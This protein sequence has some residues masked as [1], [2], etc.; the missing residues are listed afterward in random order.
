MSPTEK[1]AVEPVMLAGKLCGPGQP[2]LL[3]AELSG[4]HGGDIE[5]ALALVDAAVAAGADLVKIQT[6]RPDTITVDHDG[7]EFRIESGLWQGRTLYE[8]YAEAHTPWEWHEALFARAR[9]HGVPMFS[10]PFDPTAVDLLESL[11]CPAYKI[12]SFE[13]VDHG[14]IERVAATGKP[15]VLSTGIAS[16][17][18][19]DEAVS[20]LK[21]YP[22]TPFILLHCT[23]GYPTPI[24]EAD[25]ATI[26]MLMERYR[27]PV[28][29]S[30]HTLGI[31]VPIAAVALG[32]CLVEKHFTLDR[33][34]G[35]VDAAFSLD[36][37]EFS[38]MA[39]A[40]REA[41]L[42]IGQPR[43]EMAPV[44]HSQK[45]FRRSLYA[46]AD[47]PAGSVITDAQVRSVRPG[48]GL[49][50]REL[51][52]VLGCRAR[53]AIKKGTPIAWELL[54]EVGGAGE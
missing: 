42:A 6:Y 25:L 37:D 49:H 16:L 50:P 3:I 12:A 26:P 39:R 53:V 14:L 24:A 47:I 18:E 31:A 45:A 48:L 10:S 51:Q 28:G 20:V 13:L 23:S 27:V 38:N 33:A 22:K 4:N 17:D 11:D 8:L 44:E 34:D 2:P 7:P 9:A 30:D 29:L 46:V 41:A 43:R 5:R 19:I 1:F 54:D 40:C 36:P 15:M 21:R 32:A 52:R 35:A